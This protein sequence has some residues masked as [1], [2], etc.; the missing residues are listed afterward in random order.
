MIIRLTNLFAV[1]AVIT[2]IN[3]FLLISDSVADEMSL[4]QA[5]DGRKIFGEF[6]VSCHGISAKGDGPAATAL[7][8]KP[9]DLTKLATKNSG[10][11]PALDVA[12]YIDGRN[13]IDAHG[14]RDMP[15]WGRV[16]SQN[17]G[18]GSFG[19]EIARGKINAVISYLKSIQK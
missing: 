16:F 5:E 17:I 3:S 9:S 11:F 2:L 8:T 10:N 4:Q 13:N 18:E 12:A 15:I 6:C 14:S 7:K 1:Y 19:E